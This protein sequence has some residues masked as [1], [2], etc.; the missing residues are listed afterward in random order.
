VSKADLQKKPSEVAAMFDEVAET[1]DR[2]NGLLSFGQDR[3]WRKKVLA[4]VAPKS[5]QAILDLAAGTGASSVVFCKPGVRV[6]AGD[7]SQGMLAVGRKRHPEI[8][9]VFADATALPF[10]ANEFD[11]VTISFGLRN[12]VDT[13]K[14]LREMLRVTKPGGSLVICE[15]SEVANPVLRSLYNFYLKNFMPLFSRLAAKNKGAYDYLSESIQAWPK[16]EAL[17]AL[18]ADAGWSNVTYK[19]LTFGVVALHLAT[20]GASPAATKAGK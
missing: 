12:V 14:A 2:T 1:Y 7:F 18:I 4:A 6:V 15:F 17:K 8:E 11:T 10:G 19:N 13:S 20:K 9:F 16:Q 3:S 5:G